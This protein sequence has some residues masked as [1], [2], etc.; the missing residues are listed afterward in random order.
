MKHHINQIQKLLT[1]AE[2][3]MNKAAHL[4]Q[5]IAQLEASLSREENQK[6]IEKAKKK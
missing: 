2:E 6:V 1:K 4:Q 5:V 3:S